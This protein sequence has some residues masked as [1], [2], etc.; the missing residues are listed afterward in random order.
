MRK[1]SL[2]SLVFSVLMFLCYGQGFADPV[3]TGFHADSSVNSQVDLGYTDE[4]SG[5]YAPTVCYHEGRFYMI[6]TLS[7]SRKHFYVYT[8]NPKGEWGRLNL[9]ESS[10]QR[11]IGNR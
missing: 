11:N 4:N 3:L 7:P 8:D 9:Q 6:T 1:F 5:I 2:L 10:Y